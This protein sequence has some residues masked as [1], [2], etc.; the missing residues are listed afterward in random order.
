MSSSYKSLPKRKILST[1]YPPK[2]T[3]P[4]RPLVF[5]T[6]EYE[7]TH[8]FKNKANFTHLVGRSFPVNFHVDRFLAHSRYINS[9]SFAFS[10]KIPR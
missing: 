8:E 7:Y 9:Y 4:F 3:R 1:I 6:R 2:E 10:L 5:L